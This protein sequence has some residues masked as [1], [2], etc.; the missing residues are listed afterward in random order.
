MQDER[1][2]ATGTCIINAEAYCWCG[3]KWNSQ[4]MG[5]PD[6]HESDGTNAQAEAQAPTQTD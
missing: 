3:P 2:C 5:F 6:R 1:C 4:K